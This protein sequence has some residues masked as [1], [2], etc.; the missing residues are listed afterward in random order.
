[1]NLITSTGAELLIPGQTAPIP[2]GIN[3]I[4]DFE[5]TQAGYTT[6]DKPGKDDNFRG[7]TIFNNT[8]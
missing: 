4:G 3:M 5:V 1:V 6:A 7:L 8:I 2:P